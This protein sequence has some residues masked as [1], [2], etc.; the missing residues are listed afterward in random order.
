MNEQENHGL[1]LLEQIVSNSCGALVGAV[2]I[3]E[4]QGCEAQLL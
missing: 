2:G 3:L 4:K 1:L